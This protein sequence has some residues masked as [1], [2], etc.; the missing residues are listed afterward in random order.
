MTATWANVKPNTN[1]YE[2]NTKAPY[3]TPAADNGGMY[4]YENT[5]PNEKRTTYFCIA[6]DNETNWFGAFGAQKQWGSNGTP[7]FCGRGTKG[8]LDLYMRINPSTKKYRE[9][10]NGIIM[11]TTI[12]EI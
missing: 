4:R 10:K 2:Y 1:T 5:N 12:Q 8:I 3:A 11:P 9:F 7:A 6:N